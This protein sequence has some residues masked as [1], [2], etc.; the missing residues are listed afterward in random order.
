[1]DDSTIFLAVLRKTTIIGIG[2]IE[3]G[4]LRTQVVAKNVVFWD[5]TPYGFSKNRRFGAT[6]LL[7]HQGEKNRRTRNISSN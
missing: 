6:Y 7:N 3:A 5:V 1:M 2:T 4:R